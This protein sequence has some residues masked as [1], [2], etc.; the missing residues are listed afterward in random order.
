MPVLLQIHSLAWVWSRVNTQYNITKI[1]QPLCMYT[2]GLLV[3]PILY[4][5]FVNYCWPFN[6]FQITLKMQRCFKRQNI[7][8]G[9]EESSNRAVSCR[10]YMA[11]CY[12]LCCLWSPWGRSDLVL[13]ASFGKMGPT[14]PL[15]CHGGCG[16]IQLDRSKATR[17]LFHSPPSPHKRILF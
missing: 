16:I 15:L 1:V 11:T 2:A 8:I 4:G 7:A 13:D 12:F 10:L 14:D 6:Y 9:K 3:R 17:T 5:I